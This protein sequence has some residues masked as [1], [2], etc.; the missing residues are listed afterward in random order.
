MEISKAFTEWLPE[1]VTS[2][3]RKTFFEK[4]EAWL[5]RRFTYLLNVVFTLAMVPYILWKM[6]MLTSTLNLLNVILVDSYVIMIVSFTVAV[7]TVFRWIKKYPVPLTWLQGAYGAATANIC[8]YITIDLLR[9]HYPD[10][11]MTNAIAATISIP[12]TLLFVLAAYAGWKAL[13]GRFEN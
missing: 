13:M 5:F 2:S 9:Y 10:S 1:G 3:F 12:T 4:N 8:F 7:V 11:S 6:R